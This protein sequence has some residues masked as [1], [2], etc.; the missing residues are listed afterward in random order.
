MKYEKFIELKE[1]F[2]DCPDWGSQLAYE[3]CCGFTGDSRYCDYYNKLGQ[4]IFGECTLGLNPMNMKDWICHKHTL[5]KEEQTIKEKSK[6]MKPPDI[7]MWF[8]IDY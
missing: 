1:D 3:M 4:Y 8:D 6:E 2:S 7:S 5:R